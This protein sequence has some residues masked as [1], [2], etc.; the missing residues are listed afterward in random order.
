MKKTELLLFKKDTD[1][2]ATNRGFF[3]QYLKTLNLW[4]DIY[5]AKDKETEIF[6]ETEDD[7]FELNEKNKT[8]KFTQVKAYA[9][10]F[11]HRSKEIKKTLFNFFILFLKYQKEYDGVF[12][13]ET[14]AGTKI[15]AGKFLKEWKDNQNDKDYVTENFTKTIQKLLL[16]FASK[17]LSKRK[18]IRKD[19]QLNFKKIKGEIYSDNFNDFIHRIRWQ[20]LDKDT[21]DAIIEIN[22]LIKEKIK[23]LPKHTEIIDIVFARLLT[24]IY[25]RSSENEIKNRILSTYLL[26]TILNETS[27]EIETKIH[28]N[29]AVL[30]ETNFRILDKVDKIKEITLKSYDILKEEFGNKFSFDNFLKQYK[31]SAIKELSRVNFIGLHIP[32]GMKQSHLIKLEDVYITP[33]FKNKKRISL[34]DK[35]EE[36]HLF[37]E[38]DN[39]VPYS[40]LFDDYNKMVVLGGPGT[41]KSILV[42]SIICNILKEETDKFNNKEIFYRL[43]FRIELRRYLASKKEKKDNIIEYL[44]RNLKDKYIK[45]I[46]NKQVQLIIDNYP[47][48]FFF[49]GLDEIFDSA[50]KEQ[51]RLD[52]ENFTTSSQNI[53]SVVTSRIVGYDDAKLSED[54]KEFYIQDFN[55]SQIK[56]YVKKWYLQSLPGPENY[57]IR[58][59]EIK[60]FLSE[61]IDVDDELKC[62]PLLLSLIV[63]LFS[64]LKEIPKSKF[65]IYESCTNTLVEKWDASKQ[66]LK[67]EIEPD[68]LKYK[69]SIFAELAFWGYEKLSSD[70]KLTLT[71]PKAVNKVSEIISQKLELVEDYNVAKKWAGKFLEYAEKR[72]LYFDAEFT[73]KTFREYF[74]AL[75]IF[76]NY[77]VKHKDDERNEIISKYISNPFWFIVL[78]LLINMIDDNQAD[79]EILDELISY[80]IKEKKSFPFIL[81]ILPKINFVSKKLSKNVIENAIL[82]A[83]SNVKDNDNLFKR[84][85]LPLSSKIFIQIQKLLQLKNYQ[86]SIYICLNTIYEEIEKNNKLLPLFFIFVYELYTYP[87]P[88]QKE[89]E[90]QFFINHRNTLNELSKSNMTLYWLN[91]IHIRKE[92][93][94]DFLIHIDLFGQKSL[95]SSINTFFNPRIRYAEII[96]T[97]P[98]ILLE[99]ENLPDI[100]K[101]VKL[102]REKDVNNQD[103]FDYNIL[104]NIIHYRISQEIIKTIFQITN[105]INDPEILGLLFSYIIPSRAFDEKTDYFTILQDNKETKYYDLFEYILLG[106][107]DIRQKQNSI[108]DKFNLE[109]GILKEKNGYS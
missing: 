53:K 46:T 16:D 42:K 80:Q 14:N 70:D 73:H 94:N 50:N 36:L 104:H 4:L 15:N 85:E 74:T 58:N 56:S 66:D 47:T 83:I 7:I 109:N 62:N 57:N 39:L 64:N 76:T 89:K 97:L 21:K 69:L 29:I 65:Q 96:E 84:T 90:N 20:F 87:F 30:M 43:P 19:I 95:S 10:G 11:S 61:I 38:N 79:N 99:L 22:I 107:D 67:I 101:N 55:Q 23:R 13:F 82:T 88:K 49:D 9:E 27:K 100:E 1:A 91:I 17:H 24:E 98:H 54:Y 25:K 63:I 92:T 51:V 31:K 32:R 68:L 105:K 93:I 44:R 52:I 34:R 78:E 81:D 28:K 77:E 103:L 37:E 71:H 33:K 60:L 12:Y 106:K 6:C 45:N 59:E 102:L 40:K 2:I 3:Y 41:G 35:K 26:D 75:W 18:I 86:S 48:I 8:V 72:S 5:L 108:F